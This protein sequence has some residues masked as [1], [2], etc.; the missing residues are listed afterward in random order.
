MPSMNASRNGLLAQVSTAHLV[1]HLHIMTVPSLL[2]L[3][4][5]AM[6]VSFVEL[7]IALGLFNIIS[8]LVQAPLGFMVD[9]L[10]AKQMLMAA[11]LLGGL[12][13]G[14][15]ALFPSYPCLLIA[16]TLAGLANAVYHPAD[17]SLLSRGMASTKMGRAFSIHT[18][19]G[20]LGGAL[21]PPLMVGVA[22]LWS[23]RWAFALAALA[24]LLAWGVM[25]IG[26][27][28]PQT[29]SKQTDITSAKTRNSKARPATTSVITLAILTLLFTLLSLSLSGI[30]KFSVSALVQGFDVTL[31]TANMAL[32]AFLFASAFGVL[33]GGVLADRTDKHGYLAAAAFALAAV[34]V[35]LVIKVP[36]PPIALVIALGTAGFLTG[37]VAPS[38]DMLV[39]AASPAGAEGRTFGIVST[40]FNIGGVIGPILFGF[41][42]DHGLPS[43][44]LWAAVAFMTATTIVVLLQERALQR[45]ANAMG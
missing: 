3:L 2:P 33:A 9:R 27:P 12:S 10:G 14:L 1:S 7:G 21:T 11:L 6:N 16:M 38:R 43:G 5:G 4:P 17:Y 13:F 37:M 28:T 40:G 8:A 36:L 41:L 42:L 32:T 18:F 26:S 20:F 34:I 23:P 24:G 44:V 29:A 31:H 30:E 35:V 39:R 15:V 45:K 22:L 25:A 19:A